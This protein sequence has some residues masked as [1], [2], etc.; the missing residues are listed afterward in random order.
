MGAQQPQIRRLVTLQACMACMEG[1]EPG[2]IGLVTIDAG[3]GLRLVDSRRAGERRLAACG[4]C[5]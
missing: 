5:R 2:R 1:Q 4:V 3:F